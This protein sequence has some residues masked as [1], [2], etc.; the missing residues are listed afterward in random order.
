MYAVCITFGTYTE[1]KYIA[2]Y[3]ARYEKIIQRK[4]EGGGEE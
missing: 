1:L 3:H 2:L 4:N